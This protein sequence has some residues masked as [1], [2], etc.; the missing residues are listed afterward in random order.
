MDF[1]TSFLYNP[2]YFDVIV[3]ATGLLSG[4]QRFERIKEVASKNIWLAARC[5]NTCVSEEQE[6]VDWLIIRSSL[7]YNR[8]NDIQA[9]IALMELKEW[10]VILSFFG[11]PKKI[12]IQK[13]GDNMVSTSIPTAFAVL[14]DYLPYDIVHRLFVRLPEGSCQAASEITFILSSPA[15]SASSVASAENRSQPVLI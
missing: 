10:G 11:S 15:F 3:R 7:L 6:I 13:W 9:I 5:K 1:P 4:N 12:P 14:S 8:F 2:Q